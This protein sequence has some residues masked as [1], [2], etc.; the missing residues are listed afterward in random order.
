[1]R[2][3]PDLLHLIRRQKARSDAP[4]HRDEKA[5]DLPSLLTDLSAIRKHQSALSSDLKELQ[6]S[7]NGLWQEAI[8]SRERHSRQQETI[9]KILRFLAGVF[10][11]QVVS[12]D[13]DGQSPGGS[14]S[15]VVEEETTPKESDSNEKGKGKET[16][17]KRKAQLF[18]T[19][20]PRPDGDE[21]EIEEIPSARHDATF[22]NCK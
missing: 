8:Q 15:V 21:E 18:L 10:G 17:P 1:M 14:S 4:E 22:S 6:T 19:D 5:L 13:I 3:Q 2:G 7:N 20:G 16:I 11:G 9:N 12:G